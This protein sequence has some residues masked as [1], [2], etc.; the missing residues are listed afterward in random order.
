MI[1]LQKVA[2][3][4]AAAVMMVGL[5]AG[6]VACAP[7]GP[8]PALTSSS[9]TPPPSSPSPSPS[10][11]TPRVLRPAGL[12]AAR[13]TAHSITV[14][15]S[16]PP[17]G[18]LPNEYLI[19]SNGTVAGSVAGTVTSYRQGGLTPATTYHYRVVAIRGG[20][21]S[22]QSAVVTMRTATPPLSQALLQGAWNVYAKNIGHGWRSR[23]GSLYWTLR[24]V[25]A[26]GVC[27]VRLHQKDRRFSVG[28]TLTHAGAAYEGQG[29]ITSYRCG[30]A[31]RTISDPITVAVRVRVTAAAGKHKVWAATALRGTMVVTSRYVSS[32]TFYCSASTLKAD[33]TGT[34]A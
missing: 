1:R 19:M 18:P 13:A 4:M 12:V 29:A 30:P 21:R 16:Q 27:D 31:G 24:P 20:V 34:P 8:L 23:G 22:P 7:P 28:L 26:A 10:A 15:W 5:A 17:T 6:L 11:S 2:V 25:C 14:R 33:L 9:P 3:V 32:A